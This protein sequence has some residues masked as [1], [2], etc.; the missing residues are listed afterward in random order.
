[1]NMK[2]Y[3]FDKK[4]EKKAIR[5][6]NK[7]DNNITKPKSKEVWFYCNKCKSDIRATKKSLEYIKKRHKEQH[8]KAD[9]IHKEVV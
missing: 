8:R 3:T 7:L 4:A 5:E 9:L 2:K 6:I 1:M